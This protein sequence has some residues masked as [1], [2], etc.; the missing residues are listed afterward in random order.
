MSKD[1]TEVC[2]NVC[3][4]FCIEVLSKGNENLDSLG[5]T[6]VTALKRNSMRKGTNFL[7]RSVVCNMDKFKNLVIWNFQYHLRGYIIL[8]QN[9]SQIFHLAEAT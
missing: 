8:V 5:D 6:I 9:T 1:V 2:F 4:S 3:L 7:P